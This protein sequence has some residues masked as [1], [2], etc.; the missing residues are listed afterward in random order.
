MVYPLYKEKE[1]GMLQSKDARKISLFRKSANKLFR[2]LRNLQADGMVFDSD[3]IH[4]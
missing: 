2:R 4:I 3:G 1:S